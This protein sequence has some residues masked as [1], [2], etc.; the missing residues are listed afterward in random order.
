MYLLKDL[1]FQSIKSFEPS[2]EVTSSEGVSTFA[3]EGFALGGD[4]SFISAM[5]SFLIIVTG[6]FG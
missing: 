6:C 2:Y 1:F 4:G 5:G 3:K